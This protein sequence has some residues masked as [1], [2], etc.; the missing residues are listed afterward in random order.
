MP[1]EDRRIIF[2]QDEVYK[3]IYALSVQKQLP[4]PPPGAVTSVKEKDSDT[5][6]IVLTLENPA[7]QSI[8][9]REYARDFLAAAL[10]MFCR[11]AGI[12][13]PK[14]AKKSVLIHDGEIIL[15][16]QI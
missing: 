8:E 16:A 15:R 12:P 10:M 7:D 4:K 13:L 6:Q 5:S 2:S 11:G 1:R 3:A 9:I 14:S